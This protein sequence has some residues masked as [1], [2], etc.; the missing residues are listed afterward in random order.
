MAGMPR[1]VENLL[2]ALEEHGYTA[3]IV[4]GCVRDMLRGEKPEDWDAATSARP[5]Q[6]LELFG[7]YA[8]PTGLKHGTVTVKV[9]DMAIETTTYR[10]DGEYGDHRHPENVAFADNIEDDLSRRDFTINAMAMDRRGKLVDLFGGYGDLGK[11][12]I[13]CVGDGDRRF[14]EDALRIMRALR[15]A[16]KLG[17]AIDAD[18]ERSMRDKKEL[19]RM[20]AWERIR[21]ELT[22][23]LCGIDA[24]RVLLDYPD[25]LGVAVPEI[26]PSVG[27]DQKNPHHCYDVWEHTAYSVA[28]V[29]PD[30]ILRLTMLLH[31]LGK[32]GCFSTDDLGVGHFYGHQEASLA[33]ARNVLNRLKYDNETKERVELL[34]RWHDRQI[35]LSEK[36]VRKCLSQIGEKNLRDLLLVKRADNLAQNPDFIGAQKELDALSEMIDSVIARDECFSL[37]QLAVNGSDV[38]AL[39]FNGRE[40][41]MELKRLLDDVIEERAANDK[42]ELLWRAERHRKYG[43]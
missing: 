9:N 40:I 35:P 5:E 1:D 17:Y 16:S 10:T 41:G 38:A 25:V 20:I 26:L 37:G 15:F 7:G 33:I 43:D 22:K 13:R 12:I 42:A 3:Y 19:L 28:G 31:D 8:I 29:P 14:D 4:G 36:S 23:L 24:A 30:D 27:L 6:V 11:K 21:T 18:T 39:G 32:P 34:V 2:A